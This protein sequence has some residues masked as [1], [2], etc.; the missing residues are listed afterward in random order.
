MSV[1][2]IIIRTSVKTI[3]FLV[4]GFSVFSVLFTVFA[5]PTHIGPP[6]RVIARMR[7]RTVQSMQIYYVDPLETAIQAK[8][9]NDVDKDWKR[10]RSCSSY[11]ENPHL[12][13]ELAQLYAEKGRMSLAREHLASILKVYPD[14]QEAKAM[15]KKTLSTQR[16]SA[17]NDQL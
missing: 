7:A 16:S 11:F 3:G 15:W 12:R 2:Q 4:V 1:W 8:S 17:G 13:F 9:I 6:K 5:S 14:H 10:F